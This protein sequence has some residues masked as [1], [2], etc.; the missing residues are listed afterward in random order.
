M[1]KILIRT[2]TGLVYIALIL[3]ATLCGPSAFLSIFSIIV[4]IG[5]AEMLKL[6]TSNERPS[7]ATTA[8]DIVGGM[9]FFISSF[10]H[11]SSE[12]AF[13]SP[14]WIGAGYV[15]TRA[16]MQLYDKR[17]NAL[18]QLSASFMAMMLVVF[19]LTLLS[20]LYLEANGHTTLLAC[21]IFIWMNDTGAF[22][23]G[24]LLGR[25]RLFERISPKKSWEGFWGGMFFT[26]VAAIV[27]G[28]YFPGY[29]SE[30]T[31]M[32]W[33]GLAIVVTMFATWGD[34]VESMAK[35]TAGV[36]DS[37]NLLPGHGG[38]LDR[39]DSLLFVVPAVLIYI[40][41]VINI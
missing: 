19:P 18:R 16:T 25:H 7:I 39:I 14:I 6:C 27:I 8:I 17:R 28:A 15:L 4:A 32:Q 33:V 35:R 37:G 26:I 23:I 5:I 30:F 40:N 9:A 2:A 34:L 41:F 22:C 24:S 10:L 13:I 12:F 36:K 20:K 29:F 11:Y 21:L 31:T 38:I 1:K 3:A